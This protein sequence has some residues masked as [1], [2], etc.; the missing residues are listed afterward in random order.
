MVIVLRSSGIFDDRGLGIYLSSKML[1]VVEG[2]S[3]DMV[4]LGKGTHMEGNF[5]TK[6]VGVVLHDEKACVHTNIPPR[7]W[8]RLSELMRKDIEYRDS[9][10]TPR[11][12]LT[13]GCSDA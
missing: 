6:K 3:D 11:R 12:W 5:S 10:S 4:M 7:R 8:V 13:I 2:Y 1:V 9:N